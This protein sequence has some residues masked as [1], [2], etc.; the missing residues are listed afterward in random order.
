MLDSC[1]VDT[2]MDLSAAET[3]TLDPLLQRGSETIRRC[4]MY[5]RYRKG[6]HVGISAYRRP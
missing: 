4:S 6:V 2:R 3:M 5:V 1:L